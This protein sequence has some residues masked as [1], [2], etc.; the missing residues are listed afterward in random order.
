MSSMKKKWGESGQIDVLLVPLVLTTLL[1]IGAAAFGVWAFGSRQDYKANSDKKAAAAVAANKQVV[2]AADAKQYA[3]AAKNPLKTYA[4]PDA[5]GSITVAYPKTW[6]L[7]ADTTSSSQ[8]VDAYFHD[9]YVPAINTKGVT[10]NLR[11]QVV[12]Q[13][14]SS[15]MQQYGAL[16]KQGKAAAVPY[17]LPKVAS[18]HG[19]MLTGQ[20]L[21]G[22]NSTATA[23]L[24]AL[25]MRDKTLKI[26][27]EAPAYL[28]DF[29]TNI[30]PNLTFSP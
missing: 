30:L 21:T 23:T 22:N 19:T 3:E 26:W 9:D 15:V 25:P 29:N 13:S 11:V 6:G 28:T 12:T 18:A 27:T 8:P 17:S 1:F 4:G 16:V 14:Y 7:Y 24:V 5:Y 2:Q 10:Y 20:V